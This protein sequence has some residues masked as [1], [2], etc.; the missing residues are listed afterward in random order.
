[1][2]AQ[3]VKRTADL[4]GMR[5]APPG[6]RELKVRSN[7]L[8][9]FK[10]LPEARQYVL[11]NSNFQAWTCNGNAHMQAGRRRSEPPA[12]CITAASPDVLASGK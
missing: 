3:C 4:D 12:S 2:G 10:F 6:R 8:S 7:G 11:Q 5:D 1:M 9:V